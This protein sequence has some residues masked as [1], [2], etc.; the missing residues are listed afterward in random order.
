MVSETYDDVLSKCYL[1]KLKLP[2]GRINYRR[3][4]NTGKDNNHSVKLE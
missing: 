1:Y 3:H 2:G 4:F